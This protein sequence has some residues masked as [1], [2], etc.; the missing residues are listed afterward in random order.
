[1][2]TNRPI[3]VHKSEFTCLATRELREVLDLDPEFAFAWTPEDV[4]DLGFERNATADLLAEMFSTA[5][6]EADSARLYTFSGFVRPMTDAEWFTRMARIA[7]GARRYRKVID[8]NEEGYV[9][10]EAARAARAEKIAKMVTAAQTKIDAIRA[11]QAA[12]EVVEV[13]EAPTV[14]QPVAAAQWEEFSEEDFDLDTDELVDE[15]DEHLSA[16][17]EGVERDLYLPSIR[18]GFM[19][20]PNMIVGSGIVKIG[21]KNKARQRWNE[22]QPKVIG[23]VSGYKAGEVVISYSGEELH[24]GDI[25][26]WSK[27]LIAAVHHP[28]GTD[29]H[30]AK[31]ELLT[32]LQG[33]GTGGTAYDKLREEV[34]RLQAA[35]LHIRA[36]DADFI[37]QMAE[38]FPDDPSV[39][40][41]KKTGFVEIRVQL[42]GAS[43]TN[44]STWTIEVPRKIRTLFGKKLS[45]WFD[46]GMYYSLKSDTA[47]RLYLLYGSHVNC[48]PLKLAELREYIG[49]SM[50]QDS[51]FRDLL[52]FAHDE[53][54]AKGAIKGWRF[55]QSHRRLDT[56][57]Y[58]IDRKVKPRRKVDSK[59]VHRAVAAV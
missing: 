4:R 48:W 21:T 45:S 14:R 30:I 8:D 25:E 22:Q 35:M 11:K 41:A 1:M 33:R 3:L 10:E 7:D 55:E 39:K 18:P 31:R 24:P 13:G 51:K 15:G 47:R 38:L 56:L 52:D 16:Q 28:L 29:V 54:K 12:A 5:A 36:A 53:L 49:S 59:T 43:T 23:R 44:G 9:D 20:L 19:H 42:L 17:V 50:A 57:C 32:S 6:D 2:N 27:L 58:V 34:T 40:K 37:A 46:E 26:T